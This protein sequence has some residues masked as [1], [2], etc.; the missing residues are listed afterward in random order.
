MS[1]AETVLLTLMIVF[2]VVAIVLTAMCIFKK[3]KA[4]K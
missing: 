4:S 2:V 3:V 1:T